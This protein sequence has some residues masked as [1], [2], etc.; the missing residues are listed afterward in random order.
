M[1][2]ELLLTV[3]M[4]VLGAASAIRGLSPGRFF[5]SF[6][7]EAPL[8]ASAGARVPR[9]GEFPVFLD[10]ILAEGAH[11]EFKTLGMAARN[12]QFNALTDTLEGRMLV[13][14]YRVQETRRPVD[15]IYG[16]QFSGQV[17]MIPNGQVITAFPKFGQ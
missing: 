9:I 2:L 1:A 3:A 10:D 5:S 14:Q 8:A 16:R 15:L 7:G 17:R 11:I 4:D 6:A 12:G 13:M